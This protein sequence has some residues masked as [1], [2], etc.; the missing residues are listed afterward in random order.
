MS[1]RKKAESHANHERWLIS[2]GDFV[3]LLFALF[4]VL[5]ASS[6]VDHRKVG[7]LAQAIQVAFQQLGI[8]ESSNAHMPLSQTQP[9][10]FS[11]TQMVENETQTTSLSRVVAP[12][13]G[14]PGPVDALWQVARIKTELEKALAPQIKR[15]EV[16]L[17]STKEGLVISLEEI[18]FFNSG[19]AQLKPGALPALAKIASILSDDP[20]NLRIEGH[21]DNIPIHNSQFMSNWELSTARATRVLNILIT[22]F[23]FSPD[24]LSAAGYAQYHPVASNDTPAGRAMN[25][26]VDIVVLR[27]DLHSPIV[28]PSQASPSLSSPSPDALKPLAVPPR[29]N[30]DVASP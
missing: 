7:K 30:Q 16:R 28:L 19:S 27:N 1:R 11:D 18:G 29:P 13:T 10:P 14:K 12:P 3:T 2:Y 26:R 9:M 4:V 23:N 6:Q 21:T 15:S 17:R 5:F 24:R 25:R 22:R 8:F 20:E